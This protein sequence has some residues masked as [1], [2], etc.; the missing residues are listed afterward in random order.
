[1]IVNIVGYRT[2]GGKITKD[3]QEISN[4]PDYQTEKQ[5][6]LEFIDFNSYMYYRDIFCKSR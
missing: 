2:E 1:M 3:E 5:K 4:I 6:I